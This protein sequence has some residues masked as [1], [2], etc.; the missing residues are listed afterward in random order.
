[1]FRIPDSS[2]KSLATILVPPDIQVS[3]LSWTAPLTRVLIHVCDVSGH[4]R[5]YH[6]KTGLQDPYP[7]GDP[8]GL[9]FSPNTLIPKLVHQTSISFYVFMRLTEYTDKMIKEFASIAKSAHGLAASG[10]GGSSRG[11]GGCGENQEWLREMPLESC[12]DL[13]T[14]AMESI[15]STIS[16][17][18]SCT[19]S[20]LLHGGSSS[21]IK[22]AIKDFVI[23]TNIPAWSIVPAGG[24]H[25][26]HLT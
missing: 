6:I 14:T 10:G 18:E 3:K 23:D 8:R 4:G 16:T 26:A 5:Q 25:H 1:M 17:M 9:A 2:F 21:S 15:S 13:M 7:D 11:G 22:P 20:S 24:S 19:V 12:A